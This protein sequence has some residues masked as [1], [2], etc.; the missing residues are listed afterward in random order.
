[1][2]SHPYRTPAALPVRPPP[3]V[4]QRLRGWMG[5]PTFIVRMAI[6]AVVAYFVSTELVFTTV[7][8]GPTSRTDVKTAL[9]QG[10]P[11]A[12][13]A[14]A[15]ASSL[16]DAE[17]LAAVC[18]FEKALLPF[19]RN[20]IGYREGARKAGIVWKGPC[21]LDGGP[22]AIDAGAPALP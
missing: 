5:P 22:C 16:T 2:I 6:G 20:V 8:C 7:A 3:S 14:C 1:M 11:I 10:A 4:R 17:A 12:D 13:M 21:A 15:L 9:D 18:G 19:L